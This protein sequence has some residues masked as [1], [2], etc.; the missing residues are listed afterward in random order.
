MNRILDI[1]MADQRVTERYIAH[2][3]GISQERIHVIITNNLTKV[4]ARWVSRLQPLDG[5][6]IRHNMCRGNL[7]LYNSDSDHFMRR[8]VTMDE[9]WV[10]HFQPE[11]KQQ[12]KQRKHL[13]SPA[14]KRAKTVCSAGKLMASVFW[15]AGGVLLVNYLEKGKTI[16]GQYY[17]DLPMQFREQIK[18][19]RR[20]K[21][22]RG[23]IFHQDSPP[24]HKSVVAI[25][26]SRDCGFKLLHP[27]YSPDLAPSDF[28]LFPRLKNDLSG[29][30]FKV[31]KMS[32][33]QWKSS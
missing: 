3:V 1:V 9:T 30:S 32:L 24:A 5:K 15:D 18:V 29:T 31:K 12:F 11:S 17:V 16:T 23:V 26:A 20:G 7:E 27:P 4:S 28:Y 21:L 10:H 13:G 19:K 2:E 6:R 8:F 14:P 22:S 25:A 33:K